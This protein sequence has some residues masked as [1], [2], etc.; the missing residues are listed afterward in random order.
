[1]PS[2]VHRYRSIGGEGRGREE[3]R[4]GSTLMPCCIHR[5]GE[6]EGREKGRFHSDAFLCSQVWE[7]R[8]REEGRGYRNG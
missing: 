8:E 1:M 5:Y 2:C 4:G 6:G 7:Y 3:G